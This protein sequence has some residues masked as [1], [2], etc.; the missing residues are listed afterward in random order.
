MSLSSACHLLSLWFLAQLS[1]SILKMVAICSS[2]TSVN[3]Q[4]GFISQKLVLVGRIYISIYRSTAL[5]NLCTLLQFLNLY[6]VHRILER[7]I[8]P[9]QG[10]YLHTEQHKQNK[11]TQTSMTRVRFEPKIPVF[12][13]PKTVHA[14]DPAATMI[15]FN[16]NYHSLTHSLTHS[17]TLGA[18]RFLRSCQLCSHSRTSQRLMEPEGSLL[19][20]Q[21]PSIGSYPEPDR[22][23][24]FHLILSL[25]DPFLILSTHLRLGLPSCPFPSGFPTKIL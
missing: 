15:G 1:Y 12:E 14:W 2:E 9:S 16:R 22:S 19:R 10:R 17:F 11:R 25:L 20:S 7:G 6:T 8:S 23:N 5:V 21:E 18:E 3:F 13:C 4:H 24:P